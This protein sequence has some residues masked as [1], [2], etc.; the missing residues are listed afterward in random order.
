MRAAFATATIAL[1][2]LVSSCGGTHHKG[3]TVYTNQ[4]CIGAINENSYDE[5]TRYCNQRNEAGLVVMESNGEIMIIP[6]SSRGT[7]VEPGVGKSLVQFD[8]KGRWWV[9]SE[10]IK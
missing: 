3:D 4:E 5:M 8:G 10:F 6:G 2:S 9:A 7:L 1:L